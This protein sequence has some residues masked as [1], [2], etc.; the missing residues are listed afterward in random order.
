V[1]FLFF[2]LQPTNPQPNKETTPLSKES[3]IEKINKPQRNQKQHKEATH[4]S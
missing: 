3:K 1:S 4:K 2:L